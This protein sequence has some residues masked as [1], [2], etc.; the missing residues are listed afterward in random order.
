MAAYDTARLKELDIAHHLHPRTN[1][2]RHAKS[3]P[4]ILAKGEGVHVWDTD[5]NKYIDA[6]SGL[7]NI[8]VGHGRKVLA[9]RAKAQIEEIAYGPTFFGLATPPPIEL[10]RSLPRCSRG[11]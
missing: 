8:N 4:F 2:K 1:L 11:R 7:W 3:G 6:A 5:G 10:R 9:E